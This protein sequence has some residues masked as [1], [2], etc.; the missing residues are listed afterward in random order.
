MRRLF[1]SALAVL[2]AAPALASSGMTTTT[3]VMRQGPSTKARAIMAIPSDA[4]IDIGR[5]DR[6]W[7][8][9]TFRSQIGW[10]KQTNVLAVADPPP[11]RVVVV[12]RP[13]YGPYWGGFGPRPLFYRGWRRF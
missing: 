4:R 10:V 11:P 6:G 13:Y 1:A 2:F 9:I 5:C 7:C 3:T 8:F 12:G